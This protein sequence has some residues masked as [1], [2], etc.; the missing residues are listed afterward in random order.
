MADFP[1]GVYS[2]RTKENKAGIE[3]DVD[4]KSIG[5][6]EDVT[7]LDDEVV[8]I[9]TELNGASTRVYADNTAA[10]AGGLTNGQLYRTGDVVKIVHA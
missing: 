10:K 8:A 7:K 9:E 4:K 3:Y 2:P 6:A 5:Y 1:G